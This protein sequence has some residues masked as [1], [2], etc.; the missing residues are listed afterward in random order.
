M[1]VLDR[2]R[3]GGDDED[4]GRGR[5]PVDEVRRLSDDGYAESEI[6]EQLRDRG[7]SY[8]EINEAMNQA[9][10]EQTVE[11]GQSRQRRPVRQ[12]AEPQTG[13]QPAGGGDMDQAPQQPA[14]PA[15]A[16]QA[17]PQQ[18]E[19]PEPEEEDED[20]E[21]GEPS[22]VSMEQEELI[23]TIVS[24]HFTD[25]EDE[26]NAVY[27]DLDDLEGR[28]QELEDEVEE[29]EIREDED[30]QEVVQKVEEI[31]DYLAES[32][33]RIGGMEKAFEQV[34]PSLVEN[35]RELSTLVKDMQEEE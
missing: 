34:L 18:E 27:S 14:E 22:G 28:V 25:V 10:Q 26:F 30:Q 8:G 35:T 24:E 15:P 19:Q 3:G 17:Q 6:T 31:E 4:E 23:E 20:T 32:Q 2:F 9:V 7:Y 13:P 29:L 1:G 21:F 12:D 11:R 16:A 33:S 5:P